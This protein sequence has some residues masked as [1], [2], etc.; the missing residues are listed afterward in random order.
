MLISEDGGPLTTIYQF[1]HSRSEALDNA[2][3]RMMLS[4][5]VFW[6]KA[7]N[8]GR[9]FTVISGP[10]FLSGHRLYTLSAAH[11]PTKPDWLQYRLLPKAALRP[12]VIFA[13]LASPDA[14]PGIATWAVLAQPCV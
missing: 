13:S 10:L 9:L 4:K 3:S 6:S 7:K 8:Q 14:S 2:L 12:G 5:D 11:C 1:S